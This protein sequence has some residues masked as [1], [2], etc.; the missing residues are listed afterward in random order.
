MSINIAPF[1][2]G[3]NYSDILQ[4]N[5]N[6]YN[7]DCSLYSK[8]VNGLVAY[9]STAS[10]YYAGMSYDGITV[11][12]PKMYFMDAS[13]NE[14][15]VTTNGEVLHLSKWSQSDVD[16]D[17]ENVNIIMT[18]GTASNGSERSATN[19]TLRMASSWTMAD[20]W[21][22]MYDDGSTYPRYN[23]YD[24][25][26]RFKIR[27]NGPTLFVPQGDDFIGMG[28][29][30]HLT[31]GANV[32]DTG[33]LQTVFRLKGM[34]I[35]GKKVPYF[36][37]EEYLD[38]SLN[39]ENATGNKN[40]SYGMA[41]SGTQHRYAGPGIGN[42]RIDLVPGEFSNNS[43]VILS[44]HIPGAI[45]FNEDLTFYYEYLGRIWFTN[46]SKSITLNIEQINSTFNGWLY[47]LQ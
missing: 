22:S 10:A 20:T 6:S 40:W 16:T 23:I 19:R 25:P 27:T 28:V 29:K 18:V 32:N 11:Y 2:V 44:S 17:F 21:F 7:N 46:T 1:D 41:Y 26:L 4:I 9:R 42:N 8:K 13:T 30:W 31:S 14:R 37:E 5:C 24:D 39:A 34:A 36:P 3:V 43:T 38:R 33:R 45:L 15:S 47:R 35:D 12:T